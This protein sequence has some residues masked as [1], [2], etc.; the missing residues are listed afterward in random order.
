MTLSITTQS[1]NNFQWFKDEEKISSDVH[2]SCHNY[3]TP[4]LVIS[5]FMPEYEGEYKCQVSN[6]AGCV[7]SNDVKLG[8]SAD[9]VTSILMSL[10]INFKA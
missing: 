10:N 4:N 6:E 5:P 8:K 1:G 7:E 9:L 2:P 3:D